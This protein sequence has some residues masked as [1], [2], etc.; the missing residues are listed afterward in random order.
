MLDRLQAVWWPGSRRESGVVNIYN[1]RWNWYILQCTRPSHPCGQNECFKT[2]MFLESLL[3]AWFTRILNS[4][5]VHVFEDKTFQLSNRGC[6]MGDL[7]E[8][9]NGMDGT[10]VP[11]CAKRQIIRTNLFFGHSSLR[12][13]EVLNAPARRMIQEFQIERVVGNQILLSAVFRRSIQIYWFMKR[14]RLS[15][16]RWP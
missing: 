10:P 16:L 13:G 4:I 2:S 3:T 12:F 6:G 11:V 1:G 8:K 5:S 15:V 9:Q 14:S 7:W